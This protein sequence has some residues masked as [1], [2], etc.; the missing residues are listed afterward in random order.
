MKIAIPK[1]VNRIEILIVALSLVVG[2]YCLLAI[3]SGQFLVLLAPQIISLSITLLVAVNLAAATMIFTHSL[4]HYSQVKSL[5]SLTLI[6]MAFDLAITC[7]MFLITHPSN[8]LWSLFVDRNRNRSIAIL[9]GFILVAGSIGP[10]FFGDTEATPRTQIASIIWGII[11]LPS[12]AFW[13]LLSP[14]PVIISTYAAGVLTPAFWIVIAAFGA[15]MIAS[16]LRY[17]QEWLKNRNQVILASTCATVFWQ[18]ALWLVPIISIFESNSPFQYAEI[19]WVSSLTTGFVLIAFAMLSAAIIE[20]RKQL[21]DMVVKQTKEIMNSKNESEFYLNMWTHKMGNLLQGLVIYLDL[22]SIAEER[23]N[24]SQDNRRAAKEIA[25]EATLLNT[26]VTKLSE[27]KDTLGSDSHPISLADAISRAMDLSSELL[28]PDAV[29]INSKVSSD[30]RVIAGEMLDVAIL[31]LLSFFARLR[32]S[33]HITIS[34]DCKDSIAFV[35]VD[36]IGNEVPVEI[37]KFLEDFVI[38]DTPSLELDLYVART[39]MEH[40]GGTINYQRLH[41]SSTNRFTL[42]LEKVT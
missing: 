36:G 4:I 42:E 33:L 29:R 18:F 6:L 21:E 30:T 26:Q 22:L 20:P 23:G 27:V 24:E 10:S 11:L 41:E 2:I 8:D 32:E 28:N 15:I 14:E 25:R 39:I 17:I 1:Q 12:L 37:R 34:S 9:W 7:I 35:Y 31:C 38:P 40:L 19:I 13:F 5:R 3:L 16:F